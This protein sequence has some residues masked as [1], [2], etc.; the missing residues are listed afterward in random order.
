MT[1]YVNMFFTARYTSND[2]RVVRT[3]RAVWRVSR[4]QPVGAAAAVVQVA[5]M[6]KVMYIQTY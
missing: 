6:N 4:L 1:S 5:D 2:K 3:F